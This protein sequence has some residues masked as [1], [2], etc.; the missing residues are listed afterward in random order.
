MVGFEEI[1]LPRDG[2]IGGEADD[3]EVDEIVG[4]G[5]AA[6]RL[7]I[8]EGE[9]PRVDLV[10]KEQILGAAVAVQQRHRR[11]LEPRAKQHLP[12]RV[13]ANHT[14]RLSSLHAVCED[15]D[16]ERWPLCVRHT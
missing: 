4:G 12:H 14:E 9:A 1:A 13:R 3:D 7:P 6:N 2:V 10:V 11:R 8:D 5:V 15:P 16:A